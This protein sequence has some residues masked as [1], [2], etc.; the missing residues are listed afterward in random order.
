MA[1]SHD[2]TH[3]FYS[4]LSPGGSDHIHKWSQ[5]WEGHPGWYLIFPYYGNTTR[6]IPVHPVSGNP[7]NVGFVFD[8]ISSAYDFP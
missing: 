7:S 2:P 4:L 3:N 8:E 5:G 6:N 1:N